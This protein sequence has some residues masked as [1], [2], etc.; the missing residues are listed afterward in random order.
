M[1]SSGAGRGRREGGVS[2]DRPQT[3]TRA[4]GRHSSRGRAS[5]HPNPRSATKHSLTPQP[6][7]LPLYVRADPSRAVGSPRVRCS[8]VPCWCAAAVSRLP[9]FPSLPSPSPPFF[10]HVQ[11]RCRCCCPAGWSACRCCFSPQPRCFEHGWHHCLYGERHVGAAV[12]RAQREGQSK[13]HLGPPRAPAIT[14]SWIQY[15][16]AAT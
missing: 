1:P 2:L 8:G 7:P 11:R 9:P 6:Y 13:D 10:S 14:R 15:W 4:R 12:R 3:G 16:T 5:S